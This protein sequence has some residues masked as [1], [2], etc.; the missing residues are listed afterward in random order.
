MLLNSKD[1]VQVDVVDDYIKA[2]V[3]YAEKSLHYTFNRMGKSSYNR[4]RNIVKGVIMEEAFKGFLDSV[5]V[6]YDL[7]GA[8]HW[9]KKDKYDVGINGS[10]CDVKGFFIG[11]HEHQQLIYKDPSWLLDC[12]AL[13]PSDQV[14]S[15]NLKEND[16]YV[17]PFLTGD[18][19]EFSPNT[20]QFR[21]YYYLIHDFFD[22]KWIKNEGKPLGKIILQSFMQNEVKVRIGG[23]D[24]NKEI[25]IEE[26]VLKPLK[27]HQTSNVFQT[28]L[29]LQTNEIPSGGIKVLC[30]KNVMEHQIDQSA[31]GN[32]WIY[33][34]KV[35]IT[36][37]IYKGDF[38]EK[39]VEIPRYYKD[40]KQYSETRTINRK[41]LVKELQAIDKFL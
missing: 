16:I 19:D 41:I 17:F 34:P 12:C 23:L 40:C 30:P 18:T 22:Y 32:V 1:I 26:V 38:R 2:G 36:G 14:N 25:V 28:A 11:K 24:M 9:T 13:V 6:E 10:R 29:F 37:W 35:F 21:D 20:F 7:L 4:I 39:S 5:D 8:T 15:V 31:W 27:S 33:N 3:S